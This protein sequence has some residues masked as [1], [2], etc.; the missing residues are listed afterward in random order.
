VEFPDRL[1]YT[2]HDEWIAIDGDVVTLGI[3]AFAQD[4]L[5]EIVH[6]ELPEVG[7]AFAAGA[8]VCEVESV[9][10]VAEVYTPV[11]GEIIAVNA[12]LDGSEDTV[13]ADPYGGGWL[14][15]LRC[16]ALGPAA[17]LMDAAAYRAKI[18]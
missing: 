8:A 2:Q 9:K 13:N 18:A 15:K 3:T 4:A 17:A 11:G 10:A 1:K 14:V 12:D 16:A 7:A 6:V 5:G